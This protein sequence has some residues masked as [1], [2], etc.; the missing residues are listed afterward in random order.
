M[1]EH[2]EYSYLESK[3]HDNITVF[4][5]DM[6]IRKRITVVR[7]ACIENYP[8]YHSITTIINSGLSFKARTVNWSLF[9]PI[10]VLSIY[11]PFLRWIQQA[12]CVPQ[13][14]GPP[15]LPKT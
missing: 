11:I 5:Y 7:R 2:Y 9:D 15:K 4:F 12:T 6:L 3:H 14:K 1:M 8:R 13:A 10:T